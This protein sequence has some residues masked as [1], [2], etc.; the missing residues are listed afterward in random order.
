MSRQTIF[1]AVGL[2]LSA[3]SFASAEEQGVISGNGVNVRSGPSRYGIVLNRLDEG[4]TIQILDRRSDGWLA[5]RPT[6]SLG[7]YSVV[8]SQFVDVDEANPKYGQITVNNVQVRAAGKLRKK[9]FFAVQ[10][11]LDRGQKVRIIG[12]VYAED[13]RT[14]T[15]YVIRPPADARVYIAAEYV[16][17]PG[18][19]PAETPAAP[20]TE[21]RPADDEKVDEDPVPTDDTPAADSGQPDETANRSADSITGEPAPLRSVRSETSTLRTIRELEKDL[22]AEA[23]KPDDQR[24]WLALRKQAERIGVPQNSRFRPIYESLLGY[25]D[26]EIALMKQRQEADALVQRILNKD[27]TPAAAE[28]PERK[29][30]VYDLRG[31]LSVSVLYPPAVGEPK[32]YVLRDPQTNEITGYVQ[33][34]DNS[35]P[36]DR[37]VGKTVGVKG[38]AKYNRDL[39]L[40]IL[41]AKE[42]NVFDQPTRPT[43]AADETMPE[44]PEPVA[45]AT[46]PEPVQPEPVAEAPQPE[47]VQPEP[48]AEAP[49]PEPV[50]PE[51]V[52]EATQ[53]DII[54]PRTRPIDPSPVEPADAPSPEIP[55]PTPPGLARI[56]PEPMT[57]SPTP[58][59]PGSEGTAS[60]APTGPGKIAP[61]AVRPSALDKPDTTGPAPSNDEQVAMAESDPAPSEPKPTPPRTRPMAD[62]SMK[63]P[64]GL[65]ET[66][67]TTEEF[68][69][70]WD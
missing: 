36:L 34:V 50:Q 18:A 3:L 16:R 27:K 9:D 57:P 53:P 23:E 33:S 68:E 4:Q 30:P 13:G 32:R 21:V 1:S 64:P 17:A 59:E 6:P 14:L 66:T 10:G 25:I 20:L 42:L 44:K 41:E 19:V 37:H 51:P 5:V 56:D 35:V 28:S 47:P 45:E 65:N 15:H 58:E 39:A 63:L 62:T 8:V 46:Q 55:Q 26:D 22:V 12:R 60:E 48:V 24:D 11:K 31:L 54:R 70:E 7:C 43:L 49:Q 29:Q 67:I 38:E 2:V 61:I 52:A 69:V 40:N